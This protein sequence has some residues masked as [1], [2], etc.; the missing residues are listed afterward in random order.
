[1]RQTGELFYDTFLMLP[2]RIFLRAAHEARN[3]RAARRLGFAAVPDLKPPS[4]ANDVTGPAAGRASFAADADGRLRLTLETRPLDPADICPVDP[5]AVLWQPAGPDFDRRRR[6]IKSRANRDVEQAR[7]V[8]REAGYPAALLGDPHGRAAEFCIGNLFILEGKR[9]VT[10]PL[11]SGVLPG[12]MRQALLERNDPP[13]MV[14][15]I[16]L[17]RLM[18]SDGAFLS[19]AL[20]LI[21][22]IGGVRLGDDIRPLPPPPV[23]R[24]LQ[25]FWLEQAL[26]G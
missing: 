16:S 10:P 23:L 9:L 24:G 18:Q 2:G 15:F 26:R 14:D 25:L 8:A 17:E 7:Q 4:P 3:R 5:W 6:L 21:V 12:V 20:R 19:N 1:M 11:S 13:V 22:P